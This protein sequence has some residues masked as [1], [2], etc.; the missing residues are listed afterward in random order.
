VKE[1]EGGW[2]LYVWARI[3]VVCV[4]GLLGVVVVEGLRGSETRSGLAGRWMCRLGTASKLS[5]G[6]RAGKVAMNGL[7]DAVPCV[8]LTCVDL[9]KPLGY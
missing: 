5:V 4:E 7:A 2:K 1:R 6:G 9:E 3:Y 8:C